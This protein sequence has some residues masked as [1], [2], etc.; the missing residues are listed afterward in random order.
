MTTTL[1]RVA[2]R[3]LA[4]RA[5]VSWDRDEYICDDIEALLVTEDDDG[6]YVFA[7]VA[8]SADETAAAERAL[9]AA[10]CADAEREAESEQGEAS[11]VVRYHASEDVSGLARGLAALAFETWDNR[12]A[13]HKCD[14]RQRS[15]AEAVAS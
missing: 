4:L 1:L 6:E 11:D 5:D 12:A 3:V 7:P 14:A 2:G 15:Q 9:V 8:L 13:L 10:H